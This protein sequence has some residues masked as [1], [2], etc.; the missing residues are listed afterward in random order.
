VAGL[1]KQTLANG[2]GLFAF[3]LKPNQRKREQPNG[4][5]AYAEALAASAH[6]ASGFKTQKMK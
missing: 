5:Y 1:R 2:Q 6:A 3:S 4:R